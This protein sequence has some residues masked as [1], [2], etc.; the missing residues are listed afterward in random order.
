MLHRRETHARV[1]TTLAVPRRHRLISGGGALLFISLFLP[2][3]TQS[4]GTETR[5]TPGW[6]GYVTVDGTP[7]LDSVGILAGLL[8]SLLVLWEL[9]RHTCD[10]VRIPRRRCDL[11]S[12]LLASLSCLASAAL[13]SGAVVVSRANSVTTP[14]GVET[15]PSIGIGAA[16]ML[17]SGVMLG[18]G[19]SLAIRAY[20]TGALPAHHSA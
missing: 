15:N 9:L 11:Y 17:I 8:A 19:A 1:S 7:L 14:G 10:A 2:W 5:S 12:A 4:V 20:A 16:L 18:T 6:N 3:T 13:I